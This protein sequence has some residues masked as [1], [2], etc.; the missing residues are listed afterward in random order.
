VR[1]TKFGH[2]CVRLEKDGRSV[3]IDP[4][5]MTPEAEAG[6][7]VEAVLVT[8][9]HFDHF[10]AD[11]LL[12]AVAEDARL[13]V[14]T[15]P[16]VARHL[17]QLGDR[18]RVV[19]DGDVFDVAGFTVSVA[20]AK[21]HFSHPDAPPVDNVGFLINGEVFHPGDALTILDVPTLL[22]P[23]Q[24]PWMTVPDLISYLRAMT[25]QRAYAI[26]DGLINEWGIQVLES[27]LDREAERLGA[28]IRRLK[29]GESIEL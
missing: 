12:T 16:G 24:A 20:G 11:R 27:V 26:H 9:E 21:H 3:V 5:V 18:V 4:G 23:G 10:D 25:P 8:H 6:A 22:V 2:A 15:C 7:G 28:D 14:Y 19:G 13:V 1:L 29:P 17:G